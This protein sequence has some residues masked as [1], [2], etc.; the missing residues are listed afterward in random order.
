[1]LR[2]ELVCRLGF[3]CTGPH[4]RRR[5]AGAGPRYA[6]PRACPARWCA[7]AG[8]Q[9]CLRP[10]GK[11]EA[12]VLLRAPLSVRGFR[13]RLRLGFVRSKPTSAGHPPVVFV[14]EEPMWFCSS[15]APAPLGLGAVAPDQAQLTRRNLGLFLPRSLLGLL[16][17]LLASLLSRRPP[18]A[19]AG[20]A[21]GAWR[22]PASACVAAALPRAR[23]VTARRQATRLGRVGC[24]GVEMCSRAPPTRRPQSGGGVGPLSANH[25][26]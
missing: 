5:L 23:G 18:A 6:P 17:F 10:L 25:W 24:P 22:Q 11:A 26:L 2:S 14:A 13:L 19:V 16:L 12:M 3:L 1:M 7:H 20:H 21:C 4:P 8:P 15:E 9:R